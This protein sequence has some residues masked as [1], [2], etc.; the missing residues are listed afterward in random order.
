[1]EIFD[2][3]VITIFFIRPV[4]LLMSQRKTGTEKHSTSL[5]AGNSQSVTPR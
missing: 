3:F 1:M 4:G 5:Q 2:C